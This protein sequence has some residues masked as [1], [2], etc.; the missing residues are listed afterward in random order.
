MVYEA[1]EDSEFLSKFVEEHA[2]GR[3]LDM[4]TGTGILA[5]A[6][7]SRSDV[8]EVVAVDIDPRVEVEGEKIK[9]VRSDMF[10]NIKD[11]KFDTIVSN[12]PYLPD[13]E[14]VKDVALHGGPTGAEWILT[15][16]CDAKEHLNEKGQILLL[17]SSLSNKPL[18]DRELKAMGYAFEELGQ[19]ALFFERLYVYRIWK[20]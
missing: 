8:K 18:I 19:L 9:Y 17:F 4:G 7:A 6:A 11:E 3:V 1:R 16:I 12:P 20:A 10:S 13:D 15:F 14:D 5:R 2:R